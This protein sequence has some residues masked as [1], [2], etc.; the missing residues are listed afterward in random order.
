MSCC[1][2]VFHDKNRNK[3]K[4]HQG[5]LEEKERNNDCLI[6]YGIIKE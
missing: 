1:F 3:N 2:V 5:R 6:N 4:N